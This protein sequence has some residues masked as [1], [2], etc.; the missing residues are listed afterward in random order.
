MFLTP[1]HPAIA[2]AR[3][4]DFTREADQQRLLRQARAAMRTS[5]GV[6][7]AGPWGAPGCCPDPD[8]C[9]PGCC[10]PAG[11]SP[12]AGDAAGSSPCRAP[13][14]TATAARRPRAAGGWAALLVR[15]ARA[16]HLTRAARRPTSQAA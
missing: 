4:H 14:A 7:S 13:D 8:G 15:A 10:V 3:H 5:S 16:L 6:A 1:S 2:H 11:C 9:A 12:T